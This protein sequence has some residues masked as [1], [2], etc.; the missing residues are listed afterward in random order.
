MR[1][2]KRGRLLGILSESPEMLSFIENIEPKQAQRMIMTSESF[3]LPIPLLE[4]IHRTIAKELKMDVI[5]AISWL[6][7]YILDLSQVELKIVLALA[8][9]KMKAQKGGTE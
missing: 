7:Y 6:L 3:D 5:S 1:R 9:E 4:E 8:K 2:F